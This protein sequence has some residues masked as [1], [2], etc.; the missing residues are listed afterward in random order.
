MQITELTDST[1]LIGDGPAL[2]QR[3]AEDGYVFVRDFI[4]KD[5]LAWGEGLYRQALAAEELIDLAEERPVWTGKKSDTWRPCDAIGTQFWHKVVALPQLN[6][7][8]RDIYDADPVWI[9]IAAH[10]SSFPTGPLEDGQDL[11]SGRHQDSFYSEGM[12][13]TICW[14]PVRDVKKSDGAFAVAEGTNRR[15]ILHQPITGKDHSIL[16]G[17][18]PETDWRSTDFRVGD[19]LIF[20]YG[21]AHTGLPNPSNEFRLSLDVRAVPS[22]APKPV[23]GAVESVEGPAVT[24]RTDAGEAVTV[25]VDDNTYIRD[26]NPHPRIPT[27]E[28]EKIAYPGAHVMAM[29]ADDGQVTVLRRNRY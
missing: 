16:P 11:F 7:I 18:I 15:G 6:A 19:V 27:A 29:V 10:R 13:Y 22:Y 1:A 26:M 25:T 23:I 14:M 4:D 21:T 17:V 3:M 9:P 8:M 5:L 24:I 20:D 2:R 12:G 28:V